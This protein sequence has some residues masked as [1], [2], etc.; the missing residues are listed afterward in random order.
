MPLT[1]SALTGRGSEGGTVF[2]G[3]GS[4]TS[5]PSVAASLTLPTFQVGDL[6]IVGAFNVEK[7]TAP[8]VPT[9]YTAL[10]RAVSTSFTIEHGA[11]ICYQIATSTTPATVSATGGNRIC[12]AVYRNV[13]GIG[14]INS[15]YSSGTV[16]YPAL[17]MTAAPSWVVGI[18]SS[19][20]GT[21]DSGYVPAGQT[22]RNL[23][24]AT[25]I[26]DSNGDLSSFAAQSGTSSS[27]YA[28]SFS[29]EL[30]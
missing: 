23:G 13:I 25:V 24:T 9:G 4:T 5:A 19:Y 7:T 26:W 1:L 27:P 15:R 6:I 18:Q 30:K 16:T 20:S 22:T 12:A 11:M 17:T 3:A 29:L 14:S 10:Y 21:P 2:V 8:S 28:L